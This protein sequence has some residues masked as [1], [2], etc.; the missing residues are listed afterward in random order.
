MLKRW[1]QETQFT[2][3][4]DWIFASPTQRGG[5]PWSY[6]YVWLMFPNAASDAG[7]GKLEDLIMSV[8][9]G[10]VAGLALNGSHHRA[11]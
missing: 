8:A 5:L 6:P 10:K 3:Q 11:S 9:G 2:A 7:I 4:E 1:K